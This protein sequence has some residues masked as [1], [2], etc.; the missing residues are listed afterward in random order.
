MK[1]SRGT[2]EGLHGTAQIGPLL[3]IND[4]LRDFVPLLGEVLFAANRLAH[5][6]DGFLVVIFDILID[7]ERRAG[8]LPWARFKD[9]D[10]EHHRDAGLL[11]VAGAGN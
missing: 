1:R 5:V 8:E 11:S 2:V 7:D 9:S 6:A 10:R 3:I 4:R